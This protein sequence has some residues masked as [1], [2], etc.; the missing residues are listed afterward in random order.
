MDTA[1]KTTRSRI[2]ASVKRKNT[3]PEVMVRSILHRL[4]LRFRLHV[5]TLP[6]TPDIVLSRW[7]TAVFVHGCFWHGH[8]CKYGRLPKTRTDFWAAKQERNRTR[9][10][11]KRDELEAMGWRVVEIWT[12]ELRDPTAFQN[13]IQEIFRPNEQPVDVIATIK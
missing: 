6:G 10:A 11:A 9:D 7:H 3:G 2:M 8:A 4:G 13:R 5:A 12:C 1:T